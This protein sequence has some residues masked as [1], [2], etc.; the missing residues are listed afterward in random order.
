MLAVLSWL[1]D[2]V[3]LQQ[4]V[5]ELGDDRLRTSP[6]EQPSAFGLP[7]AVFQISRFH[8]LVFGIN[9]LRSDDMPNYGAKDPCSAA[10]VQLLC[11]P[12]F[13]RFII[14]LYAHH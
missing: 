3:F 1:H 10:F 14:P 5:K 11:N 7:P 12:E 9:K 6:D 13:Q 4:T 8:S 2:F